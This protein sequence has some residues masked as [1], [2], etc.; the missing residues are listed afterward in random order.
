MKKQKQILV[1]GSSGQIGTELV[2]ELR[3]IYGGSN[4]VAS[5]IH[6]PE[7]YTGTDGPYETLDVLKGNSVLEV[8]KKYKV[9]E[10]YLLAAILSATAEQSIKAAWRLNMDGLF[11]LLDICKERKIKM[12]WPSSIAAFGPGTPKENTPQNCYMDPSTVYGISKLAGELWCEYYFQKFGVD[13]R[14]L[15]YPGLISYKAQPGGGTTDYAVHIFHEARKHSRYECYLAEDTRLPMMYMHDAVRAT[16]ELMNAD[17]GNVKVRSSY[18]VAAV[19]FTPAE[20]VKEIQKHIS[21]FRCTYKPDVRQQYA[22]S[23]PA[24]IDDSAARSDWGWHHKFDLAAIT[25]DMLAHIHAPAN[26]VL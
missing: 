16:V 6:A 19:S 21:D 4:V 12:F 3:R 11:N 14:S 24:S 5:D 8:V 13:V 2:E 25:K 26:A 22:A 17:F 20:M 10:V 23:W 9:T 1:I 18:N 7:H 15:R